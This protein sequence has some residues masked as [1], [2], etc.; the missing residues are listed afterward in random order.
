MG[1]TRLSIFMGSQ[2]H[3]SGSGESSATFVAESGSGV[4]RRAGEGWTATAA[5][6]VAEALKAGEDPS[7]EGTGKEALG[8]LAEGW[9]QVTSSQV[10]LEVGEVEVCGAAVV[11]NSLSP[12]VQKFLVPSAFEGATEAG[13]A[14][15][16]LPRVQVQSGL[17]VVEGGIGGLGRGDVLRRL[18]LEGRRSG[19]EAGRSSEEGCL[20]RNSGKSWTTGGL[21]RGPEDVQGGRGCGWREGGVNLAEVEREAVID[22]PG[23]LGRPLVAAVPEEPGLRSDEA[24]MEVLTVPMGVVVPRLLPAE[25]AFEDGS[26]EVVLDDVGLR[27]RQHSPLLLTHSGQGELAPLR[28]TPHPLIWLVPSN[29]FPLSCWCRKRSLAKNT[30]T[31][32]TT[33]GGY[34]GEGPWRG[35]GNRFGPVLKGARRGWGCFGR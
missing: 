11:A 1:I 18:G 20:E 28:L 24:F 32:T 6:M 21:Q 4:A 3:Q 22:G 17:S 23:D 19:G 14:F 27:R 29:Q 7:A 5:A 31:I 10:S 8:V 30:Y 34:R 33:S 13:I 12:A 16:A 35:G 2:S 25:V 26:S 15:A 9:A